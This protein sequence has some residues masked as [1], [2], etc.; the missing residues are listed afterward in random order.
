MTLDVLEFYS[1]IGGM[2]Y[3]LEEA[4]PN[5]RVLAAFDINTTANMIYAH[6]FPET[7]LH[8]NNIQSFSSDLL[9]LE[10]TICIFNKYS[11]LSCSLGDSY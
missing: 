8:Q 4:C 7:L 1:G 11:H 2:H 6:N 5:S 9:D 10:A 3:A